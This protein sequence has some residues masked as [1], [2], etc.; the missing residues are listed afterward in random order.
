MV[1]VLVDTL[2]DVLKLIPFLFIA[3]LIIEFIEHKMKHKDFLKKTGKFAP[4]CGAIVGGVP[5]CG[6]A[7]LATNLYI[8]R[9]ISL[10]TLI[11]VYLSTSDEMLPVMLSEEVPIDFA[12]KIVLVKVL[13]GM[14]CG[15]LIDLIYRKKLKNNYH[16]C[17]EDMCHCKDSNIF[18]S[19]LKHT[20]SIVII[21]FIFNLILNTLFYFGEDKIFDSILLKD[22][23]FGSLITSLIGLIPNCGASVV[24]TELYI[25]GA[26]TLGSLIG[27]LLTGAG[28]SLIILFKSNNN[29][30]E[31]LCILGL[32]YSIGVVFGILIDFIL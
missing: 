8:T 20:F 9:I 25:K 14:L 31:N 24:V 27:G 10:G 6:F 21:I 12:I 4:A 2:L 11:A 30:K 1:D 28:V 26:I 19:S 22:T 7:A 3:F 32:L 18:I 17:D 15:F 16:L 23:K 5:Q 29:I 13:I